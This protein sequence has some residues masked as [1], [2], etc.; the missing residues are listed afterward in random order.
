MFTCK[1]YCSTAGAHSNFIRE[2]NIS[3]GLAF[4]RTTFGSKNRQCETFFLVLYVNW[5]CEDVTS[6]WK[7]ADGGVEFP[8]YTSEHPLWHPATGASRPVV[9][10]RNFASSLPSCSLFEGDGV[11]QRSP[12]KRAGSLMPRRRRAFRQE[13]LEELKPLRQTRLPG[14]RTRS[15]RGRMS[16]CRVGKPDLTAAFLCLLGFLA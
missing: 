7:L 5:L 2:L 8:R 4:A 12:P 14:A 16:Q 11:A 6:S 9:F 3:V 1:G 15:P 13:M 10:L